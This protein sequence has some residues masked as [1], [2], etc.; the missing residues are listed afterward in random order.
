MKHDLPVPYYG[1]AD[2]N[3]R[4]IYNVFQPHDGEDHKLA[5]RPQATVRDYLEGLPAE[6]EWAL[7]LNGRNI[8]LEVDG[9]LRL[10]PDDRLAVV[11]IPQGSGGGFKSVLRLALQVAA[12]A[13]FFIPG[14]GTL[15]AAAIN[16]AVG[17]FNQFVLTPHVKPKTDQG[18]SSE[19]Y[20]IDGAKNSAT[21]NIPVP[22]GYG[23][24]RFAGNFSDVY[25]QNIGDDQYLYLRSIV[26][27]GEIDSITDVE[28][29]EQPISNFS[30]IEWHYT[31]GA[32]TESVDPWFANATVANNQNKKIDTGWTL[33]ST[34]GAVDKLRFDF[35]W[36]SGLVKI[37]QKKGT[38]KSTAVTF[39]FQYKPR[40]APDSAYVAL[41]Q[42][43]QAKV[44]ISAA[45][46]AQ[47]P[48]TNGVLQIDA[49]AQLGNLVAGSTMIAEYQAPG[50]SAWV[51]FGSAPLN[52]GSSVSDAQMIAHAAFSNPTINLSRVKTFQASGL[53]NGTYNVRVTN[54]LVGAYYAPQQGTAQF[55]VTDSRTSQI[56]RSFESGNLTNGLYDVRVR[57]T[58]A[59]STDQ[60]LI[61][62]V[63]LTDINEITVDQIAMRGRATLSLKI[64]LNDQLSSIPTVTGLCKLSKVNQYDSSGALTAFAW[65]DSP[66][67]AAL[68][69]MCGDQRGVGIAK[70]R[71][72]WPA[73]ADWRQWCIDNKI[74]FNG[75]FSDASN[76]AEVLGQ[77]MRIGRAV[78]IKLGTKISITVDRPDVPRQL[79]NGSNIIKDTFK[80]TYLPVANR[81]NEFEFSY[82]DK[83]DRNKQ[84]TVRF[85]DPRAIQNGDAPITTS[86]DMKGC[87]N[88]DQ[89]HAELWRTLYANRVLIRTVSFDAPIE[90][91]GISIG[92]VALIQHD[93]M[94]W[95]VN[96]RAEAGS[97]AG[98]INMD[99]PA[100]NE[101]TKSYAAIVVHDSL[102]RGTAT[103]SSVVGNRIFVTADANI[104]AQK[105][106]HVVS[107]NVEL[108][109]YSV[110]A[111]SPYHIITC[112]DAVAGIAPGAT[113]H[114]WDTQVIEQRTVSSFAAAADGSSI[115]TLS[116]P[117]SKAPA[118][119]S[120]FVVGEIKMVQKPY[121][122]N[123]ISGQ[124]IEARTL[125]FLEYS[126]AVYGPPEQNL[127]TPV[128]PISGKA[129]AHISGLTIDYQA[130]TDAGRQ[131]LNVHLKWRADSTINYD[132][133]DIYLAL[134]G[135]D[136]RYVGSALNT[137]EYSLTLSPNDVVAFK[138]IAYNKL[139]YRAPA[140]EAL[141]SGLTLD[142]ERLDVT[143]P[144]EDSWEVEA[145]GIQKADGTVIPAIRILGE[146]DNPSA[147]AVVLETQI[148]DTTTWQAAGSVAPSSVEALIT[149]GLAPLESYMV[150]V[151][152]QVGNKTSERL[153]I[154]PVTLSNLIVDWDSGIAGDGKPQSGATRNYFHGAYSATFGYT[155]GDQ[156]SDQGA[157]WNCVQATTG[158]APPK[159]PT[160]HNDWWQLYLSA[161]SAGQ[162]DAIAAL[163]DDGSITGL[164]KK[165]LILDVAEID[166]EEA[167]LVQRASSLSVGTSAYT[168]AYS[169]LK[170]FLSSLNPAWNDTSQS[171]K[172]D[173]PTL[174][175][176]IQA[177]YSQREALELAIG[178][179]TDASIASIV[180]DNVIKAGSEKGELIRDVQSAQALNDALVAVSNQVNSSFGGDPTATQRSTCS[181][182]MAALNSYLS[183]LSPAW[184][185]VSK[186]T[187]VDGPTLRARFA[188]FETAAAALDKANQ[189]YTTSSAASTLA[190]LSRISSD[191]W[192]SAGEK[193]YV[194]Q[195]WNDIY[196]E[197]GPLVAQA[198]SL[199]VDSS[200]YQNAYQALS[201]Y[202]TSLSPA[203]N[204]QSQDTAIVGTT[205]R[206]KFNDY[207]FAKTSLITAMTQEAARSIPVINRVVFSE[208]ENGTTGWS[209][210]FQ[211]PANSVTTALYQGVQNGKNFLNALGVPRASGDGF[212][213]GTD[214]AFSVTPGERLCVSAG[215]QAFGPVRERQIQIIFSDASGN[216]VAGRIIGSYSGTAGYDTR[217]SAFGQTPAGAVTA[218]AEIFIIANGAGSSSNRLNLAITQ[219]MVC[220]VSPATQTAPAFVAGPNS[221][222]GA[223]NT[224]DAWQDATGGLTIAQTAQ[225]INDANDAASS[226]NDLAT[227]ANNFANDVADNG[228]VSADE[229]KRY[230]QMVPGWSQT[231]STI[232]SEL[233][234]FGLTSDY[235][236]VN[237]TWNTF[238]GYLNQLGLSNAKL[239]STKFSDI[240]TSRASFQ[241]MEKAFAS[242]L[243]T[244]A[245]SLRAYANTL[246]VSTSANFFTDAQFLRLNSSKDWAQV[247]LSNGASSDPSQDGQRLRCPGGG[248]DTIVKCAS[249]PVSGG[250]RIDVNIDLF[251]S[252]SNSGGVYAYV[253][254]FDSYGNQDSNVQVIS[255]SAGSIGSSWTGISGSA[256]ASSLA[257]R[258]N[259]YVQM[260]HRNGTYYLRNPRAT[261]VYD[262]ANNLSATGRGTSTLISSNNGVA[263]IRSLNLTGFVLSQ[264]NAG[265]SVTI[266]VS[267]CQYRLDNGKVLTFGGASFGGYQYNTTYFFS[268]VEPNLDGNGYHYSSTNI[269]DCA[270]PDHI[271][272]GYITTMNS[273]GTGGGGGGGGS[274]KCVAPD[275]YVEIEGRGAVR[276]DDVM[277][278]D[279]IMC[280]THD[281]RD[282]EFVEVEANKR[283]SNFLCSIVAGSGEEWIGSV[284]TPVPDEHGGYNMA[285]NAWMAP[286]PTWRDGV[287]RSPC[288][289]EA[290]G[291]G[292][293][294]Q[295]TCH[296]RVYAAG[297]EP[298]RYIFT[299]NVVA[300]P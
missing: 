209:V 149:Q 160:D 55:T 279:R 137:Q 183:G 241:N 294:C 10:Q 3:L 62:E 166:A 34:K 243:Q 280:L 191:N 275:M 20:G 273:G 67:D 181:N 207:E 132:G 188:T 227:Q 52:T 178:Q 84:K 129:V 165:T 257:A 229:K 299:H 12:I 219:V 80:V 213:I 16:V 57:R 284:N 293:V 100:E 48:V 143:P 70:D 74:T 193:Q 11:L 69:V 214:I 295:I 300:K 81:A 162:V 120:L 194:I 54:G 65:S 134:N 168:A 119:G 255:R 89:A 269:A 126:D 184:N 115:A 234:T 225:A 205:F 6:Q 108:P 148:V 296:Q 94:D 146:C 283:G 4:L 60:Y 109:V 155:I 95:A 250:D 171:T 130:L 221:S 56:R 93:L 98:V 7:A 13:A 251:N 246:S 79:F 265:N 128:T 77:I 252:G 35:T 18:Q 186:D 240:G 51:Q 192:L 231:V 17:L 49:A 113:V 260:A 235:N 27:D 286:V 291:W 297:R 274:E 37:D 19:T 151:S 248:S 41:T 103:V 76:V 45:A 47:I 42:A 210:H 99:R 195:D 46:T 91:V 169:A 118:A 144:A 177:Y 173:G 106:T 121:R 123:G 92:D 223:D 238:N 142:P 164:E 44:P 30:N 288:E 40:G 220:A 167:E 50:S 249:F 131:L 1:D 180:S 224:D 264:S 2:V 239:S 68:D 187:P 270:G 23:Q 216:E 281:M 141:I 36:T 111:G 196:N 72:D 199:N 163:S 83:A 200:T 244:A 73:F 217:I 222:P 204:D 43:G 127:P 189:V 147:S 276:A 292:A 182:A 262:F 198:S 78:P 208:F 122:L 112:D 278:G 282:V 104:I 133:A 9:D 21:E 117:F 97:T 298:G 247:T 124:G 179:N 66:A 261:R 29:N 272:L 32:L 22:V 263:G 256:T 211:Q 202:L 33:Y 88:F 218:R 259:V 38:Y 136:F 268:R 15:A 266:N 138:V 258:A 185:D 61:D 39:E 267:T 28:V 232:L 161:D 285:A 8:T 157:I 228:H 139:G 87:D 150:G 64:K 154:G 125:S 116:S 71:I 153:M 140:N 105:I 59:T 90:S 135:A 233:S 63:Y 271:Y 82:Y 58:T 14:V 212:S 96:G 31:K 242:A 277:P 230:V 290:I 289:V 152:Y 254:F 236:S 170:Q 206:G 145:I 85:V 203:W 190:Q 156:V 102:D 75:V 237:S 158:N 287:G 86:V 101:S 226:A 197:R 176:K 110:V 53:A 175:S 24:F 172:V 253:Q 107:G 159:L 245:T 26:N 114:L 215:V 5:W 25:T 174:R 201:S